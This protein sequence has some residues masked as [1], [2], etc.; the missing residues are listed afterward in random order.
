MSKDYT[1]ITNL[2]Q[3]PSYPV[4]VDWLDFLP[5]PPKAF[6]CFFGGNTDAETMVRDLCA[7]RGI[8]LVVAPNDLTENIRHDEL[9]VL[10][11][12]FGN[13]TTPWCI[14]V[15][16]DTLAYRDDDFDW[17]SY[18]IDRIE[19]ED[20]VYMSGSTKRYRTDK[21]TADK[22]FLLT[23]RVSLNFV[24]IRPGDWLKMLDDFLAT[25]DEVKRFNTEGC[26]EHY[27]TENNA[28]G[29]R[30]E[31]LPGRRIFHVQEWRPRIS[32][33]RD[34]F[35]AGRGI[36]PFME[37]YCEDEVKMRLWRRYYMF[38]KPSLLRRVRISFGGWR[39]RTFSQG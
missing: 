10:R 38:P 31:N 35:R 6:I 3:T 25:R 39:R 18:A 26:V 7:A 11:W 33:V 36:E 29:L 24:L 8:D 9:P 4:L 30:L 19:A 34:A 12:Q 16:L 2:L 20:L 13:V 27:C 32:M 28:W 21:P 14:R 37:G 22:G 23:Q 15:S 1:F 5:Y 17:L